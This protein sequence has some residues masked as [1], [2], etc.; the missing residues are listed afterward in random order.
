MKQKIDIY[1][2]FKGYNAYPLIE[3]EKIIRSRILEEFSKLNEMVEGCV[4][5]A[6][7]MQMIWI[8]EHIMAV[9]NRME[10][11]QKQIKDRDTLFI[12]AYLKEKIAHV[13]EEKLQAV[14][15]RLIELIQLNKEII[16]SL[17]CAETDTRIIDKFT[18]VNKNLR[19]MEENCHTRALLLKKEII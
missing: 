5:R 15:F 18:A 7:E 17:S 14:D 1:K 9:K 16:D 6:K 19:E 4:N 13:D 11:M 2:D 8:L 12:P 3:A 10:R